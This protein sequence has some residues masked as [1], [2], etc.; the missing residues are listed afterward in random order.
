LAL[1]VQL[2]LPAQRQVQAGTPKSKF[3]SVRAETG[4]RTAESETG[5]VK[6]EGREEQEDGQGKKQPLAA[7]P[8]VKS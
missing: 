8:S 6:K 1:S 5:G 2:S 3:L 7:A 4:E